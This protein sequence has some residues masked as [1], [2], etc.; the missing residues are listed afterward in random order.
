M[1]SAGSRLA[2]GPGRGLAGGGGLPQSA[3]NR[4]PLGNEATP[5]LRYDSSAEPLPAPVAGIKAPVK[6]VAV[7]NVQMA[8]SW[9]SWAGRHALA[10]VGDNLWELD[11]RTL[12]ARLGQHEF[13]FIVN[14]QWEAGGTGCCR[15][16]WTGRS[17]GRRR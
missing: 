13:K 12:G 4:P 8:G 5:F 6:P 1:D 7:T 15:S 17:S 10:R 16:I 2:S 14:D 11:A 3:T 9:D